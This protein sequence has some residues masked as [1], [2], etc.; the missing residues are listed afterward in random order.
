[1]SSV[2][3]RSSRAVALLAS[4][5][6]LSLA[7]CGGNSS[8]A[9]A[10]AAEN[11]VL[12]ASTDLAEVRRGEVASGVLLTGSLE[13]AERV[14]VLAQVAGTAGQIRADRGDRVTRGQLLTTIEAEGVRSQA[15]GAQANVEAARANVEVARRQR[16]ASRAL[17]EQGAISE[18]E[19]Q[20]TEAALE[21][22]RAQL[23]AAEAQAAG[24]GEQAGRTNIRAPITGV[25]SDRQVEAGQAVSI[26]DRLFEV[27]DPRQLELSGRIPV[28]LAQR[29]RVGQPVTFTLDA[30]PGRSFQGRVNRIDPVADAQTRQVGIYVRLPNPNGELIAGQFAR[31]RVV[32]ERLEDVLVV[33]EGAIRGTG[34]QRTVLVV[35]D[36]RVVRRPVTL[37]PRDEAQGV[38]VVRDGLQE[39]EQVIA[40]PGT[41]IVEGAQVRVADPRGGIERDT[42]GR[43][44]TPVGGEG[45]APVGGATR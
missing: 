16:D 4:V 28:E 3:G 19:F 24:A 40:T 18:L 45:A 1:M 33:P 20:R 34:D 21:A 44:S 14:A 39:G 31:G 35:A 11:V 15:A 42:A 23:A 38:V 25:V 13:P 2:T 41:T 29:V 27:V 8:A 17:F 32:G 37:G 12:L 43:A 10:E 30:Y 22:A 5:A 7:A 9:E 6:V 26:G 36:G